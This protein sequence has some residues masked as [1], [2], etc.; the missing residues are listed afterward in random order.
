MIYS[1]STLQKMYKIVFSQKVLEDLIQIKEFIEK[2][3]SVYS[4]KTINSI[5]DTINLLNDFPFIWKVLWD[6]LREIIETDYK[7][8]IVY[9]V[10]NKLITIL[11]IYK[12][13]K[14]WN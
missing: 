4:L 3:N 10:E 14:N 2:D 7:Y 8:K 1:L 11:S 9:K 6:N 12:Y 13:Q 5:L